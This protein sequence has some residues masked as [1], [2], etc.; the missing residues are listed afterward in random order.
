MGRR[1]AATRLAVTAR[2][3]RATEW[4]LDAGRLQVE[5]PPVSWTMTR[6]VPVTG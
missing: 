3:H 2:P 1:M 4:R 5:L 6:L